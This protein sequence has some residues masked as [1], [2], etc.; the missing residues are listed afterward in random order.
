MTERDLVGGISVPIILL[1]IFIFILIVL[2]IHR[3]R[4]K[5]EN[6]RRFIRDQARNRRR[7][8]ANERS[9]PPGPAQAAMN[10]AP[11]QA[12]AVPPPPA[13]PTQVVPPPTPR[14]AHT[15][16]PTLTIGSPATAVPLNVRLPS[17][18][19]AATVA[20]QPPARS[21]RTDFRAPANFPPDPT[22][23]SPNPANIPLPVS[24]P[25]SPA[26]TEVRSR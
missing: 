18:P 6:E 26:P 23:G 11:V 5:K 10:N 17:S 1:A 20:L 15:S 3:H 12:P 9:Q 4:E 24:Q 22:P 21:H 7:E 25:N 13:A 16:P 14:I 19:R 8:I 2:L